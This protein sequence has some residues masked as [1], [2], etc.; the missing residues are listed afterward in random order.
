MEGDRQVR[1]HDGVRVAAVGQVHA[2]WGVH[3]Q[4]RATTAGGAGVRADGIHQ[5]DSG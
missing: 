5:V 3:R 4:H 2:G 1:L